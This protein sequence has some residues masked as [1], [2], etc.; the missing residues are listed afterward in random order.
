MMTEPKVRDEREPD[1]AP[2][3]AYLKMSGPEENEDVDGWARRQT[4]ATTAYWNL[5]AWTDTLATESAELRERLKGVQDDALDAAG[6]VGA[7][8][9]ALG[10]E[11]E[12]DGARR[13]ALAIGRAFQRRHGLIPHILPD[14]GP[15][16]SR[17]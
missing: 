5:I 9:T 17:G 12:N 6:T 7:M 15:E 11:V 10:T 8:L 13:A 1:V 2:L 14:P 4:E 3:R 16:V